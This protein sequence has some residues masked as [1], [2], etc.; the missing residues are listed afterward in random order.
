MSQP[1]PPDGSDPAVSTDLVEYLIVSVPERAALHGVADALG[2]LA[3]RGTVRIL[4]L[5]VIE[6]DRDGTVTIAEAETVTS[7]AGLASIPTRLLGQH[8]IELASLAVEP[9]TVGVVIVTEDRWA[10]PLSAAAR[11]AGGRIVAGD[12]IPAQRVETTLA[13]PPEQGGTGRPG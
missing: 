2:V 4:D 3:S 9:G 13:E 6:R 10:R 5:V 1:E 12:R 8:D 11:G 7:L